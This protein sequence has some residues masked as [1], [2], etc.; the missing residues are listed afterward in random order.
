MD[1][2][3]YYLPDCEYYWQLKHKNGMPNVISDVLVCSRLH[4][5]SVSQESDVVSL[6]AKET[7]YCCNKYNIKAED[8]DFDIYH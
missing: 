7:E 8:Y 6:L 2:E 4:P 5:A 3:L 1:T